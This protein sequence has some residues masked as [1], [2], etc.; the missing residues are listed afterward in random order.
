ML[1]IAH[2]NAFDM[3]NKSAW[4]ILLI[5][6][7]GF[8]IYSMLS[9]SSIL[10]ATYFE[11][12]FPVGNLLVG[13]LLATFPLIFGLLW[14]NKVRNRMDRWSNLLL[15]VAVVMGILWWPFGRLMTGNWFNNFDGSDPD[16]VWK[17]ASFWYWTY[18]IPII[19]LIA[20]AIRLI[21]SLTLKFKK[22]S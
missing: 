8:I 9:S 10:V 19:T 4:I 3:K 14:E 6:I 7:D 20:I 2:H 21:S 17:N 22:N 16:W 13:F 18:A 5:L 1:I 12:R 15:L 11:G